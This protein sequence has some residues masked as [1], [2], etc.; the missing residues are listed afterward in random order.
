MRELRWAAAGILFGCGLAVPSAAEGNASPTFGNDVAP[1]LYRSCVS[2]HQPGHVAPMSLLTYEEVRPWAMSIKA[3]VAS[4]QMPPG[5][6][7]G[8]DTELT[9]SNDPRLPQRDI[10]TIVAWA[11]A[12]APRGDETALPPRPSVVGEW[13]HPSGRPPDLVIEYPEDIE[14]PAEGVV[15]MLLGKSPVPPSIAVET[16]VEAFQW[17]VNRAATHHGTL[18]VSGANG[19][20]FERGW[21][22]SYIPGTT[23][24]AFGDGVAKRI[25]PG[26]VFNWNMHYTTDGRP[27]R[28]RP[29]LGLWW[30]RGPIKY[31][32]NVGGTNYDSYRIDGREFVP[33]DAVADSRLPKKGGQRWLPAIPANVADYEVMGITAFTEEI[34]IHVIWP[35]AHERASHFRYILVYPDGREQVLLDAPFDFMWQQAFKLETPLRVPAGSKMVAIG[36]YDNSPRNRNI[37]DSNTEVLWSEQSWDEMF[38][39]EY[40][41]SVP[42]PSNG[43]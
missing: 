19:E 18:S 10:D 39:P 23:F 35:H 25:V 36:R 22:A 27:Y 11:D 1:I 16:W 15:P 24:H 28:D 5:W 40:Y 31:K 41:Y 12:G 38:S 17:K 6:N 32:L 29:R 7:L 26:G 8:A 9:F 20:Q 42:A 3:K 33:T 21:L 34:L 2:C 30:A 13:S 43:R 14:I 4:R 37:P